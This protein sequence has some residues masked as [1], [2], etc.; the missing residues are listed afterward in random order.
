VGIAALVGFVRANPDPSGRRL[1]NAAALLDDGAIR[2]VQVK[3][4][5]PSYDVFDETRYFQPGPK[6][7]CF[8]VAGRRVGLTICED[9]W[10]AAALGRELYDE[11]PVALLRRDGASLLINMAASPFHVDKARLREALF[12]R[13]ARRE[14]VPI[15]YVNQVGGNDE[16]IF[17]GGS[18]VLC[19]AGEVIARAAAFRE[20]LLVVD[21][22][23]P[24][25]RCEGPAE[26]MAALSA[27]L[28]LGLRDYVYKCGF[29]SVVLGLSGGIDSAVV[30]T[31][32]ADALGKDNVQALAM[33]SRYSSEH[34]LTDAAALAG[35]F[36]IGYRV[37]EIEPMHR[38]YEASLGEA[39]A[40]EA[41][42]VAAENV[43]ARIRGNVVMAFSNAFGH[44]PLATGNKSE[45]SVGYCT[46]Y[47]DM[48]GGLAPIGDVL[49]TS[50]LELAEQLNTEAGA[51]RIPRRIR[52]KPPS[53]ELKPGQL[54]Q[55]K[56]PPYDLL[57]PI[58]ARYIEQD[59]TA[60]E[61]IAEGFAAEQV[62]RVV[63]MVDAAEYKRKQ[64][65]PVLK[66]TPRAFG[67]GRRMPI[68]QRYVS[69]QGC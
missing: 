40:G 49:K 6:P 21:T 60:E 37:V 63:A 3:S 33:P 9:L 7:T 54:D 52:A 20:D 1:Q 31:L 23:G 48:T 64:A 12:A 15:V 27:A 53:A 65:A 26:G 34:S 19:P 67:A 5:L 36:G 61:I 51:E 13:Q 8:Q 58:L 39:L 24:R 30:A 14:N 11:D 25:A 32:A 50:V 44:L 68:A 45:L 62:R 42:Q 18:C 56:L 59:R 41:G 17:D 43:Q 38:A 2:H 28:K 16:L 57:D 47:G 22:E 4:L 29:R 10:D 69:G 35:N 66:V 55:D 46:L